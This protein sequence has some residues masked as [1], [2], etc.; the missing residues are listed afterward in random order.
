MTL[1][2]AS[3]STSRAQLLRAAGVN[4]EVQPAHV[5][6]ESVKTSL[7]AEGVAVPQ[8]ADALAELKALRVSS[9]RGRDIVLGADQ[10]LLFDG[11]LLSKC[12][13]MDEAANL[14]HRLRAKQHRLCCAVVLARDGAPI[15]R[16]LATVRL[17]MRAFSDEFLWN[18]LGKEGKDV[19]GAV[20][21]Y[22]FEGRGAQLFDHVEG[23][24]FSI[25]GLPLLPL[26][27]AL[28]NFGVIPG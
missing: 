22:R 2:L 15:W 17:T 26:L 21:C 10:V 24:Y 8:I 28:R 19:L 14:L 7:L 11:S 9:G 6:E 5:D 1:I 18:Y 27:G 16:H 20:G 4:F 23:D 25:L 13:S 3:A 12:E